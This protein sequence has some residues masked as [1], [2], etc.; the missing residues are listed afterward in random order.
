MRRSFIEPNAFPLYG[1]TRRAVQAVAAVAVLA[2]GLADAIEVNFSSPVY[3]VPVGDTVQVQVEIALDPYDD[4]FSYGVRLV[5]GG[6]GRVV[7]TS[8][9]V[10]AELDYTAFAT[11]ATKD[12]SPGVTG[13][14]GNTL[15]T[16]DAA[17]PYVGTL[18][19]TFT[20]EGVRPGEVDLG[21]E[22]YRTVGLSEDVFL[23]TDG[24]VLDPF[25]T[26]GAATLTVA[27]APRLELTRLDHGGLLVSYGMVAGLRYVLRSSPD[28]QD[29]EV[30]AETV[31]RAATRVAFE[32]PGDR[33]RRTFFQLEM[34][35]D[36]G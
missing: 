28:L 21:L 13:V 23:S 7:V 36:D 20:L 14:K 29:W 31:G 22:F 25:I 32:V 33:G 4:L 3:A 12:L 30:M 26:F 11:G 2:G 10:P 15:F 8:V 6:P 9:E 27:V 19:A 24:T 5:T 35:K 34:V 18:L 1:L 17:Q 16:E